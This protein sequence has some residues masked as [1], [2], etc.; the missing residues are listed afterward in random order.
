[1]DGYSLHFWTL[2]LESIF[3]RRDY[4]VHLLHGQIVGQRAME[5]KIDMLGGAPYC[6]FMH[7]HNLGKEVGRGAEGVFDL[8]I[9]LNHLF[10]LLDGGRLAFDVGQHRVDLRSYTQDF[11][12]ECAEKPVRRAQGHFFSAL[13][14]EILRV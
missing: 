4:E 11:S 8:T 7:V 1:M 2:E 10:G 5:R 3:K 13:E 14:A 9:L 6:D 12:F